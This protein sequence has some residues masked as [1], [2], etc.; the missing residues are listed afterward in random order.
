MSL[1]NNEMVMPVAPMYASGSGGGGNSGF[2]WG[3]DSGWWL[4]L[5]FLFAF[6]GGWG[7]GGFNG[8]GGGGAM[9]YVINNDVQRGFDQSAIMN[10]LTGISTA[11]ANGF[12]NAE[13]SRANTNTNTLQALWGVQSALQ[14]CCCENR[15]GLADLKYTVATENCA[16]RQALNDGVRDIIAS[17]TAGIQTILDKLCDQEL[18]AA[19]REND[20]LRQ[21]LTASTLEASQVRQTADIQ[22]NIINELR[23]CPIPAQPVY[24]SQPIFTCGNNNGCGCGCNGNF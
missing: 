24:G 11:V 3:G 1:T 8:G 2:G 16:D 17:Q 23:S 10:G 22:N 9:P 21:Q 20:Q 12:A 15:A 7:N 4:I 5:L 14:N 13:V 19:R 18:Q 6:N